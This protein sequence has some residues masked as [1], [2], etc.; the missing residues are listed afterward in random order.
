[1]EAQ[2]SESSVFPSQSYA[3]SFFTKFPTDSRFLKVAHQSFMPVRI[4]D[5]KDIEFSLDRYTAGN[6]ILIQD[7]T[8]NVRFQILKSDGKSLPDL[9]KF[10]AP[11]NNILHTLFSSVALYINNVQI[12]TAPDNYCYKAYITNLMSYS[13]SAKNTHLELQGY[14]D[15]TANNFDSANTNVNFGFGQRNHMFRTD[16]NEALGYRPE[17]AFFVGRLYHELSSCETGLP[18]NTKVRFVLTKNKDAFILQCDA[19][20]TEK[21]QVKITDIF[22]TVPIAQ[23]SQNVY[24]ELSYLMSKKEEAKPVTIQYRKFEVMPMSVP[25]FKQDYQTGDLFVDG[26]L[27]CRIVLAFVDA[28]AR[29]G[30]YHK[31]PYFFQRKWEVEKK[32]P[33][34][35]LS[36]EQRINMLEE[37]ILQLTNNQPSNLSQNHQILLQDTIRSSMTSTSSQSGNSTLPSSSAAT[38]SGSGNS[39]V[40]PPSAASDLTS[41]AASEVPHRLNEQ[42]SAGANIENTSSTSSPGL[43]NFEELVNLAV[44]KKLQE[45]LPPKYTKKLLNNSLED[46]KMKY[47]WISNIKVTLNNNLI[48]Q[49]DDSQTEDECANSYY[50]LCQT[51]GVLNTPFSNGITYEEFRKGYFL[52]CYDLSTSGKCGTNYV[53]PTIRSGHLRIE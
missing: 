32:K 44:T 27:P 30:S 39:T 28:K 21:Y 23:L 3:A 34:P 15:D 4:I 6:V 20:D 10:V 53:I 52:S 48:D 49:I 51:T 36:V 13:S 5:G 42:S 14:S 26:D 18:P 17:G 29:L 24:D 22:L 7:T 47:V 46:D 33:E 41:S 25:K 12:S 31:N 35:T 11:R 1:M 37:L 8:I 2:I 16:Y 9:A 40:P 50:R 43:E 38:S 19:K 45:I